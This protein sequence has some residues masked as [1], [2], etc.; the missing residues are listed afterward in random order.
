[1]VV[2]PE[3]VVRLIPVP[4]VKLPAKRHFWR[5]RSGLSSKGS[6]KRRLRAFLNPEKFEN[7]PLGPTNHRDSIMTPEPAKLAGF[8][9]ALVSLS[10]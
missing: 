8:Y 6:F 7:R 10:G 1:M 4:V 2:N 3:V 5:L 9:Y